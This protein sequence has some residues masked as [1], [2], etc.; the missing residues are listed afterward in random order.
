MIYICGTKLK[1]FNSTLCSIYAMS[2]Y[3]YFIFSNKK[4][5]IR[6]SLR[7]EHASYNFCLSFRNRTSRGINIFRVELHEFIPWL[8]RISTNKIEIDENESTIFKFYGSNE[9]QSFKMIPENNSSYLESSMPHFKNLIHLPYEPIIFYKAILIF[10]VISI[11]TRFEF[12]NAHLI[13]SGEGDTMDYKTRVPINI[14]P[15]RRDLFYINNNLL[16][17]FIPILTFTT[18]I[19]IATNEE[20]VFFVL[21]VNKVSHAFLKIAKKNNLK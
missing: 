21:E 2:E 12:K 19:C 15:N 6:S 14:S 18:K 16:L 10:C 7:N 3:C 11:H 9:I 17:S 13:I 4:I 20:H 5:Y 8:K 1:V